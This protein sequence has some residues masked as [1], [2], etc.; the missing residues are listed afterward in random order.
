MWTGMGT[1]IPKGKLMQKD[2]VM[3]TQRGMWGGGGW[4]LVVGGV[5]RLAVGGGWRLA[6]GG[7]WRLV[8][9]GPWGLSLSAV[10][11]HKKKDKVGS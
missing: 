9:G 7:G 1:G 10:L 8:V 11:H 3:R 6:V 2:G 5:W 4:P